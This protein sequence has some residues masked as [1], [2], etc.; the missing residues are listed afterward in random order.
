MKT[1]KL[2]WWWATI[3]LVLFS[4]MRAKRVFSVSSP[5]PSGEIQG[6]IEEIRDSIRQ[7]VE[8]KI[9]QILAER[10]KVGWVG[11]IKQKGVT[12][13][14]LET[15]KGEREV[16]FS[17]ETR[18]VNRRSQ[19]KSLEDLTEGKQIAALGYQ[20][21]ESI[22]EAKRI[23]LIEKPKPPKAAL[24]GLI[25][26]KSS[27][28]KLLVITPIQDKS[29]VVEIVIGEKSKITNAADEKVTYEELNK[30]QKVAVVYEEDEEQK[31]ALLIKI[32]SPKKNGTENS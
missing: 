12:S 29:Q 27:V 7:Q 22:L 4:S 1:K 3:V 10:K 8:E 32:L 28:E 16:L 6:K 30:G 31:E 21:G 18:V 24:V 17:E 19:K 9:E 13:F 5:T 25:S 20:Q 15:R 2:F 23:I 26:D 11:I 14:T